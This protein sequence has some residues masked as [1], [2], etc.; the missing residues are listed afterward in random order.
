[1][2]MVVQVDNNSIYCSSYISSF[3]GVYQLMTSPG[4]GRPTI[5]YSGMSRD[6]N[7]RLDEHGRCGLDNIALQMNQAAN[8]GMDVRVRYA[9]ADSLLEARAQEL[10]L[11]HQR[12]Y[13]WNS[14]NN[15][16]ND[17]YWWRSDRN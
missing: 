16:G 9:P 6:V 11:L 8:R 12:N 1:M 15:D 13:S 10:F 2:H 5:Q 14:R 7:R 4:V 3:V 17:R